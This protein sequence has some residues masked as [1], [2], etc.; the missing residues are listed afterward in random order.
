MVL[1]VTN[2]VAMQQAQAKYGPMA[3]RPLS[4]KKPRDSIF[5]GLSFAID[6]DG[7][8]PS[9]VKIIATVIPCIA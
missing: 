6:R 8:T 1:G 3:S 7:H 4:S 5:F 9:K 2:A